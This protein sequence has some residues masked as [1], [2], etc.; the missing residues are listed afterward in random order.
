MKRSQTS[1]LVVV[2]IGTI[3][4]A[5]ATTSSAHALVTVTATGNATAPASFSPTDTTMRD[6]GGSTSLSDGRRLWAF[7]DTF[8]P[9]ADAT[10]QSTVHSNTAAVTTEA[11]PGIL[12][13]ALDDNGH[14]NALVP[15]TAGESAFSG[16]HLRN[17]PP[18]RIYDSRDTS[19][20]LPAGAS[21][22]VVIPIPVGLTGRV[23]AV[24]NLTGINTSAT[25]GSFLAVSTISGGAPT[26]SSLNLGF[27]EVA[28]NLVTAPLSA[29]VYG[30]QQDAFRVTASGAA[31]HFV[32]DLFAFSTNSTADAEYVPINPARAYDTALPACRAGGTNLGADEESAPILLKGH[33]MCSS[34]DSVPDSA[35][36]VAINLTADGTGSAGGGFMSVYPDGMARPTSSNL[37]MGVGDIRANMA[38]IPLSD[39]GRIRIYNAT[40]SFRAVVD[41]VGYFTDAAVAGPANYVPIA[42]TRL[43]DSRVGG[44]CAGQLGTQGSRSISMPRVQIPSGAI[45]VAFNV[46]AVEPTAGTFFRMY[47]TGATMPT[48][49]ML[50][51]PPTAIRASMMISPVSASGEVTIYNAVGNTH[52]V[53]DILGFYAPPVTM[54][55]VCPAG[56]DPA[57]RMAIW[58]TSIVTV[59]GAAPPATE[60]VVVYYQRLV[61]C[62]SLIYKIQEV[63]VAFYDY[64]ANQE[65]TNVMVATRSTPSLAASA[66]G[67]FP[68]EAYAFGAIVRD[69]HVYVY[70]CDGSTNQCRMG[71]VTN[72]WMNIANPASYEYWNGAGYGAL[73]QAAPLSFSVGVVPDSEFTATMDISVQWIPSWS[74][75][76]SYVMM[77]APKLGAAKPII[78]RTAD[79]PQGPWSTPVKKSDN[80]TPSIASCATT[81]CRAFHINPDTALTTKTQVWFSYFSHASLKL[82]YATVPISGTS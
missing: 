20:P 8:E 48:T 81:T 56:S 77:Y 38:I 5:L 41:I 31:T 22:D 26:T 32:V 19:S 57:P 42:P 70:R 74:A 27:A 23:S 47:A 1:V 58:P 16:Q 21:R 40:G 7:G 2:S 15:L 10:P 44:P 66:D 39:L 64:T 72:T 4:A 55:G 68:S 50:N 18:Q 33:N 73:A 61:L 11:A 29:R 60:R 36:A 76:G 12:K 45:A 13:E 14:R 78:I 53:I 46:T 63:G 80:T 24:I 62:T 75:T 59:G 54:A 43:C 9:G 17:V 82:H 28:A 37:N 30:A 51:S 6:F 52:Y 34:A 67:T 25:A 79:D 35:T 49:S 65:P 71:R 69:T 3:V